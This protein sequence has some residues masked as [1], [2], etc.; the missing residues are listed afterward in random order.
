MAE[1]VGTANLRAE[2][3]DRVIKGFATASYKFK[4]A[5]TISGM[6]AWKGTFF[7]ET[8]TALTANA[9]TGDTAQTIR[10]LPRGANFPQAVVTW[11]EVPSYQEKYGLEDSIF[12]EDILTNDVDVQARTMFRIAEGVAKAVDDEIWTCLTDGRAPTAGV[13][14]LVIAQTK[15]W[16]GTSAAI[17]D[18]LMNAKQ[19]I[20]EYNYNTE[21]AMC[22]ISPRDHRSIVT[23]LT[24]KGA[25][26][27]EIGQAMATNGRAGILVGIQLVV[28]NSVAA[29]KALVVI[30]KICATWKE[31]VTLQSTVVQDAYKGVKIRAVE[32]GKTQVTDPNAIVLISNTQNV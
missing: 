12:W 22:F 7:R 24:G 26:F 9:T 31:A 25:Q 21:N 20:A 1:E 32:I 4:Q 3:V 23:Y 16:E 28:S 27:P 19:K 13:Q 15:G 18:D 29:S 11:T 30:P 10:G 6:N 2:V 14:T 8:S 5:C 17:I